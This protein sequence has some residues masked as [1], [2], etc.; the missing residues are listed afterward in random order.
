VVEDRRSHGPASWAAILAVVAVVLLT[1]IGGSVYVQSAQRPNL[2]PEETVRAYVEA[3]SESDCDELAQLSTDE[4]FD[5]TYCPPPDVRGDLDEYA[6]EVASVDVRRETSDTVAL[7]ADVTV[8][9]RD[10]GTSFETPVAYTLIRDGE[11]WYVDEGR[12]PR[13]LLPGSR[14]VRRGS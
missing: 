13:P 12:D 14:P 2:S 9:L 3:Q 1:V 11:R 6:L 5:G 10:E 8:T 7:L 4:H